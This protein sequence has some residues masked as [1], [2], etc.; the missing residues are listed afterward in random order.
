MFQ[1]LLLI[2]VVVCFAMAI[3]FEVYSY[4]SIPGFG[5]LG[6]GRGLGYDYSG[7]SYLNPGLIN[8]PYAQQQL[9]QNQGLLY[10]QGLGVRGIGGYRGGYGNQYIGNIGDYI[11]NPTGQAF[12]GVFGIDIVAL[13]VAMVS[14]SL[15]V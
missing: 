8:N 6:L 5:A 2:G 7:N 12:V 10:N 3:Y 4:S 9:L 11:C 13:I 1:F 14:I 15:P